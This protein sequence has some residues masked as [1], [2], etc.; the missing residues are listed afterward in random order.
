MNDLEFEQDG[1]PKFKDYDIVNLGRTGF[2]EV[3][4]HFLC[5]EIIIAMP[6]IMTYCTIH[7]YDLIG[8]SVLAL[9]RRI[10]HV[11][12]LKVGIQLMHVAVIIFCMFF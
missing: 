3:S 2:V 4:W 11:P 1:S 9:T 5:I 7:V 12:Q 8:L 10:I 6:S